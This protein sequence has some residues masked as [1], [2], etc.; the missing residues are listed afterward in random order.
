MHDIHISK[1]ERVNIEQ[2]DIKFT[3]KMQIEFSNPFNDI[4]E[5]NFTGCVG[6]VISM[7]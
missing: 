3:Y 2:P 4:S 5:S 1:W 7:A 6:R